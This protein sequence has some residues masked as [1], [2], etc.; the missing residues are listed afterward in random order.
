ME[1]SNIKNLNAET[2][3]KFNI[4]MHGILKDQVV[5]YGACDK[6]LQKLIR[7]RFAD[8]NSGLEIVK[9]ES[10]DVVAPKVVTP[11][12]TNPESSVDVKNSKTNR[13]S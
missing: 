13:R 4:G 6:K 7:R 2:K 8:K 3:L 11:E 12:A 5:I 1:V 9:E 10:K